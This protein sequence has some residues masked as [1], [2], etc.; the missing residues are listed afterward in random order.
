MRPDPDTLYIARGAIDDCAWQRI[1]P[2]TASTSSV[3]P[4][5]AMVIGLIILLYGQTVMA[6]PIASLVQAAGLRVVDE[7]QSAAD[8]QLPDLSEQPRRLQDQRGKVVLLNF[9]AT[10]CTP[11]LQEMPLMDELSQALHARRTARLEEALT[12]GQLSGPATR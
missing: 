2:S 6:A 3:M 9:W 10:W 12:P 7:S 1:W 8:C 11:C 4:P 5:K